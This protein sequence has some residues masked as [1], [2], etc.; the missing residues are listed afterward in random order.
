MYLPDEEQEIII[1][2]LTELLATS[3]CEGDETVVFELLNHIEDM[4]TINA[5]EALEVISNC[6]VCGICARNILRLSEANF[7]ELLDISI[8]MFKRTVLNLLELA[9]GTIQYDY[10]EDPETKK[11]IKILAGSFV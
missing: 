2:E 10:Y 11:N 8:V 4:E 9:E 5:E 3:I 1:S 7:T 6:I